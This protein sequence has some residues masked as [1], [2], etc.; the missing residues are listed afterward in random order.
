MLNGVGTL[1]RQALNHQESDWRLIRDCEGFWNS[2]R[3]T[4]GQS[5]WLEGFDSAQ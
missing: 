4:P 2:P 3:Q 1:L 5:H